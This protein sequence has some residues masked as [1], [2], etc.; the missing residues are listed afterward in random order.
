MDQFATAGNIL[1]QFEGKYSFQRFYK[2]DGTDGKHFFG[3]SSV[4]RRM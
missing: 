2:A 4:L 3:Q 1:F